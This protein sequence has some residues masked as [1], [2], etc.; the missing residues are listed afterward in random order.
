MS[1]DYQRVAGG[2]QTLAAGAAPAGSADPVRADGAHSQVVNAAPPSVADRPLWDGAIRGRPLL[3]L[4]LLCGAFFFDALG[5]LSVFTAGPAIQADLGLSPAGL[6]WTFTAATL[7]AGALLLVGGRLADLFGR[8][9]M[10]MAGLI[11]LVGSSLACA[12]APTAA[13]LIVA[14]I[15][16]G[17]AAAVLAPAALSLVMITFPSGR[18]R[19]IAL[20]VWSAIGGV[21]ATAGLLLGGVIT[22][23]LG[24]RW[25]FWINV[26]VGLIAFVLSPILI[27]DVPRRPGARRTDL[28]G[29]ITITLGLALIVY[30]I[31]VGPERGWLEPATTVPMGV[32]IATLAGFAW[33]ESHSSQPI[34]PAWLL[35]TPS[36][37]RGNLVLLVAGICT[38]GLLFTLTLFTQHVLRYSPPQF[39]VVT[40]IMTAVSIGGTYAAQRAV[41]R[42]GD[43]PVAAGGLGLLGLAGLTFAGTGRWGESGM[44]LAVGMF[45]FGLG[46]GGALVA[47]S[48]AALAE[49]PES[50]AGVAAGVKNLSFSLGTTIGVAALSTVAAATN[51]ALTLTD[52]SSNTGVGYHVAFLVAAV[53]AFVGCA[54]TGLTL[55]ERHT[56][57][58]PLT[59]PVHP[60]AS[61]PE[62]HVGH[63]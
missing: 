17:V 22:L 46:I 9:R 10:F 4:C 58:P 52:E 16:Q 34:I 19:T 2:Q 62:S 20:A 39:G 53:V 6:Q 24:W 3:V 51:S 61:T 60:T 41:G 27:R 43:R 5:S 44:A 14:R 48:V 25:V 33:V 11:L 12:L 36:L 35:R 32:G 42:F 1:K 29:T 49:V 30:A 23:G 7:P 28:P 26:P 63:R 38:D 55:R 8:R 21:G 57:S 47:G 56:G 31:S 13:A 50:D 40:T 54:T 15:V 37:V 18:P 45:L 59:H